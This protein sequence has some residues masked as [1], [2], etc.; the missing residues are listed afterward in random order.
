MSENLPF[1]IEPMRP[2]DISAVM[3]IERASFPTP[4]TAG[5]Y[6]RELTQ[7]NIATYFVLCVQDR[8]AP[9]VR[10]P[11]W[12]PDLLRKRIDVGTRT[13]RHVI[14]YAG[15]WR[16]PDEAHITTIAI[17]PAWRG[18]RL[19][20]WLVIHL[21][22][23]AVAHGEER[24]GLEVRPSNAPARTLYEK[25]GFEVV[26]RRRRYYADG[27]DAVVMARSDIQ[28]DAFQ[29]FLATR[30]AQVAGALSAQGE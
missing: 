7:N 26:K 19:G 12:W 5:G 16:L 17:D 30:R 13:A 24:A 27:E 21:L 15:Y 11:N 28:S 20:E 22:A 29:Q 6:R 18:R 2:Q 1:R 4:W 14:G 10:R 3:R 23:D 9:E 25:Y 8:T